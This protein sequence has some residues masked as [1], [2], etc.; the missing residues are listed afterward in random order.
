MSDTFFTQ[1]SG[2]GIWYVIH[3]MA[4]H[5]KDNQSKRTF[6]RMMNTFAEHFGCPKCKQH[7]KKFMETHP[8]TKYLTIELGFFKWSWELHNDINNDLKKPLMKLE[9]ALE[10]YTTG[11]CKNCNKEED[12][13]YINKI[14]VPLPETYINLKTR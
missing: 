3:T 4:L 11:V 14:L 6:A 5:A 9:D 13:K 10:L 1:F 8:F 12:K 7:I 2:S